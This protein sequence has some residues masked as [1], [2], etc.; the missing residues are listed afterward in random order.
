M[1]KAVEDVRNRRKVVEG[2]VI[3]SKMDKTI[4]V[5]VKHLARHSMYGRTI[6]RE[7]KYKAHD[8][9]N[10]AKEGDAVRIMETRRL[11]KTKRWRLIDIITKAKA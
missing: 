4:T 5:S 9:K 7:M 3:S 1:D 11:S 8:E 10:S 2:T 6:K